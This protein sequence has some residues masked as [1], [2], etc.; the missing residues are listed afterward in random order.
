VLSG[1]FFLEQLTQAVTSLTAGAGHGADVN[2]T[3]T[4]TA[5]GGRPRMVRDRSQG[6]SSQPDH[7]RR[8]SF[9]HVADEVSYDGKGGYETQRRNDLGDVDTIALAARASA[10]FPVAFA[11]VRESLALRKRRSWPDFAPRS[12]LDWLADG[13]ILDNTP[14]GPVL[15]AISAQPVDAPW[16][17]TIC[18][19]VPSAE[20]TAPPLDPSTPSPQGLPPPWTAVALAAYGT[21]REVDLREDIEGLH[22]LIQ[23]GT[24]N[25]DVERFRELSAPD[26]TLLETALPLATG[27]FR[28]YQQNR[29]VTALYEAAA[30]FARE[31]DGHYLDPALKI[32]APPL[33][34]APEAYQFLPAALPLELPGLPTGKWTW[35]IPAT[36]RVV[37]LLLRSVSNA[38]DGPNDL[39]RTL[40]RQL[41]KV[42]AIAAAVD[43]ELV[44]GAPEL[45]LMTFPPLA[46][47]IDALYERLEVPDALAL[48]VHESVPEYARS[49]N[50]S[51]PVP[52]RVLQAALC[53]EVANHASGAPGEH[54]APPFFDF[55][56]VGISEPP[57]AFAQDVAV[58]D[59]KIS[60]DVG[61]TTPPG[62]LLYGTRL[63]HF[64]AFGSPTWRAWDW[65][66]GRLHAATKL[67]NLLE[68]TPEESDEIATLIVTAEGYT[69][70]DVRERIPEVMRMTNA[71]TLSMLRKQG[72]LR[73][74][75]DAFATLCASSLQ[76]SPP[77]PAAAR[78]VAVAGSRMKPP[79]LGCGGRALRAIATP[80]R[81]GFWRRIK[82][83]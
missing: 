36:R 27:G 83:G 60:Q 69:L 58:V 81:Y 77:V 22:A 24:T 74:V 50:N 32:P 13:G 49:A 1:D 63:G 9:R 55:L 76:T 48:I 3:I 6:L 2:L 34:T 28:L 20:E 39:R 67:A 47:A 59:N 66:W 33:S 82:P 8:F 42:D 40:S 75:V 25:A 79:G 52:L 31:Q 62:N 70:T 64:G 7:R 65:M 16:Q 68:L 53:V 51:S 38:A 29:Y 26:A 44:A 18:L 10:S 35:G 15:E 21:P 80:V 14:F 56:R 57:Q 73:D 30:L 12:P 45:K 78:Q 11:P 41:A 72:Q 19:I 54:R 71:T 61:A 43:A 4:A 17:R 46:R 37:A 23:A 5:M